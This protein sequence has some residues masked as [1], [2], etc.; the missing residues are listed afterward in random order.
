MQH[1][2]TVDFIPFSDGQIEADQGQS[3]GLGNA[4]GRVQRVNE[5]GHLIE[6]DELGGVRIVFGPL[7]VEH[8]QVLLD[9]ADLL[10]LMSLVKVLQDDGDVHVDHDHEVD[11]DEGDE[12]DDGHERVAAVAVGQP[13]EVRIAV[14]R[15]DQQ[16][17]QDVVPTGRSDQTE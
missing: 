3:V 11:D 7:G 15:S 17:L 9:D 12:V 6:S 2:Q 5:V 14:R 1:V 4:Q 10:L 16:R 8:L 13:F